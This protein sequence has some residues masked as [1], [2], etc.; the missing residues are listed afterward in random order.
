[1]RTLKLIECAPWVKINALLKESIFPK[2]LSHSSENVWGRQELNLRPTDYEGGR[3][4]AQPA[5]S[6]F[7]AHKDNRLR[8]KNLLDF[9]GLC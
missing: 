2:S 7:N 9:H 1:S 8:F 3:I 4:P 6:N 5:L